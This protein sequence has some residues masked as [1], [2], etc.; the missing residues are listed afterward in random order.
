MTTALNLVRKNGA[1]TRFGS[2]PDLVSE[3]GSDRVD[4]ARALAALAP[5]QQHAVV[6]HYIA[7]LPIHEIAAVMDISEGT[8][9]AHLAQGRTALRAHLEERHD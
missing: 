1:P 2:E 4:V 3:P 9:K 5:R 6:L 8:V 7:D